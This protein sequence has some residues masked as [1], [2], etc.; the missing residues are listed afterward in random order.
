MTSNLFENLQLMK[1]SNEKRGPRVSKRNR[2]TENRSMLTEKNITV[3]NK[4]LIKKY[5][6]KLSGDDK[7]EYNVTEII[8]NLDKYNEDD[9]TIEEIAIA[10]Q[11][12]LIDN[13]VDIKPAK[14]KSSNWII[15]ESVIKN[16]SKSILTERSLRPDEYNTLKNFL[17]KNNS[18]K[19]IFVLH[20]GK[21]DDRYNNKNTLYIPIYGAFVDYEKTQYHWNSKNPQSKESQNGVGTELYNIRINLIDNTINFSSTESYYFKSFV[22]NNITNV[23]ELQDADVETVTN[24]LLNIIEN[25]KT[26]VEAGIKSRKN[27]IYGLTKKSNV[28]RQSTDYNLDLENA[29]LTEDFDSSMPQWLMK[30]VR[31]SN[32]NGKHDDY[33]QQYPLDTLKWNVTE[34]PDKGK[35]DECEKN[36]EIYAVL[37]DTSGDR[38]SG[39]YIVY[40]PALHLNSEETIEINNRDRK[41][42]TISLKTLAPYIKEFAFAQNSSKANDEV[43]DK[44]HNRY[45]DRDGAE[46][47][48]D[49]NDW[50]N[51]YNGSYVDKSGY[52]VDPNKYKRL[53]AQN[54]SSKYMTRL[55][56][57]Y[58]VLM[59]IR[60]KIKNYISTKSDIALRDPKNKQTGS[61]NSKTQIS[62][63]M[64]KYDS[65]VSYYE[66][67]TDQLDNIMKGKDNWSGTAFEVFDKNLLKCESELAKILTVYFPEEINT[68]EE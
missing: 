49:P 13:N 11:D 56:D 12:A 31:I 68:D 44:R 39:N 50:Y 26:D 20:P 41:I 43:H 64:S 65:A 24:N 51:S 18:L 61:Y 45:N 8:K 1:E 27:F 42:R 14:D 2:K 33:I 16:K 22:K 6:N 48:R 3:S 67:A 25:S 37:I 32:Q 21:V 46:N 36:G 59:D 57:V 62:D 30:G 60:D 52:I 53:L 19:K 35:L 15:K 29:K 55:E 47:R 5:A 17:N 9:N 54:N 7:K 66:W 28:D 10:I 40:S 34:A 38:H 23:P 58:V 63:I 4:E